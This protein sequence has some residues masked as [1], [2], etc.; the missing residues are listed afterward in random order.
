MRKWLFILS[1]CMLLPPAAGALELARGGKTE[2]K[3]VYASD[4]EKEAAD[5]L[6]LHLDQ[7]TGAAFPVEKESPSAAGPAIWLGDTAFARKQGFE[8]SKLAPEEWVIRDFGKELVIVG[9]RR[10]A[11]QL[12]VY[13]LLETQFGCRWY[14]WDTTVIPKNPNLSLNGINIRKQPSFDS[15]EIFDDYLQARALKPELLEKMRAY[16]KRIG[17]SGSF[18]FRKYWP[19][20]SE[21]YYACHNFYYFVNPKKYFKEHPEYFSMNREG[22]RVHGTIGPDMQGGNFCLTH[23]EVRNIAAAKML[24]TIELDRK[25]LPPRRWPDIY[26]MTPMDVDMDL[27]LC[28]TCAALEKK[29]GKMGLLLDFINDIARRVYRKYPDVLIE[30]FSYVSFCEPPAS[31][32]PEKNVMVQWCN[33]YGYND[34]YRPITH[35][36]NAGQKAQFDRWVK[37]GAKLAI[38]AYWNMADYCFN[39]PRVE[40]MVDAIAPE[41]RYYHKNGVIKFFTQMQLLEGDNMPNFYPLQ[42]Y[43]GLKLMRDLSL[44]ENKLIA[45][46]MK[47]YFGPAEKPMSSFLN[48]LRKAVAAVPERMTSNNRG[49][50]YC[51]EAFMRQTW[52]ELEQAYSLT[53]PGTIYRDHVEREM[54][55]PMFVIL[56]NTDWKI[57]DREKMQSHYVAIRERL[58]DNYVKNARSAKKLRE[59]LRADLNCFI[60]LNL[61]VP[62]Q[63]KGREVRILGWTKMK[64]PHGVGFPDQ[65]VEDPD[66]V[67]GK[68]MITPKPSK[69]RTGETLHSLVK[70]GTGSMY[71]TAVGIYDFASRAAIARD[72]KDEI[73]EDEKYHWYKVGTYKLRQGAFVWIFFWNCQCLLESAWQPDDGMPEL[74]DWEVWVSLKFTGPAYA[75]GS[76]QPDRIW[77]DQ[78]LLVRPEKKAGKR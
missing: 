39:P 16:H 43:L 4:D 75:E 52:N 69:H 7:I 38:W 33:L 55:S 77:W 19:R 36:I 40:T 76:K 28:P 61:P 54:L 44:D 18:G 25:T 30:T 37:T 10:H 62:E 74:N 14:A 22:K 67:V 27:C 58:L 64:W 34:C 49:R 23:P 24:E 31:I 45:D 63:F 68:A 60:K 53:K 8:S 15:R 11:V 70:Q 47:A 51:T 42:D 65:F 29:E 6:K 2:Y 56:T 17:A 26:N 57:G 72:L 66:S 46:F 41:L 50:S 12:G 1:A 59:K 71:S 9:G 48:R 3:I 20:Y 21:R 32:R 35:P 5:E 78:V 73:A 13:D